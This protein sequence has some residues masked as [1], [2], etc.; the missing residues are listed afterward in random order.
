MDYVA[1][2]AIKFLRVIYHPLVPPLCD[3]TIQH[4]QLSNRSIILYAAERK[5]S[6][7]R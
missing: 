5:M 6:T 2:A 3:Q 7:N 1:V 4:K